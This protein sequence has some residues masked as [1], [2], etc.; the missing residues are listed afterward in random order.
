MA[1][2]VDGSVVLHEVVGTAFPTGT[3]GNALCKL[4]GNLS[5]QVKGTRPGVGSSIYGLI[6]ASQPDELLSYPRELGQ[7]ALCL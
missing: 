6:L 1:G 2:E 3:N 4:P 5:L 7:C